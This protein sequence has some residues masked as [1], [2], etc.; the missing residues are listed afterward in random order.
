MA[1]HLGVELG[2]PSRYRG[3]VSLRPRIGDAV[4]RLEPEHITGA[5][6]MLYAV[7]VIAALSGAVTRLLIY[8]WAGG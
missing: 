6:R 7:S 4:M 3:V 2:G 8:R 5:V 1:G